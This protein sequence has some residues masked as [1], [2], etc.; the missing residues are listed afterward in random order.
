LGI[1]TG[2]LALTVILAVMNGFQL[3]FI[4][5]ILE[6]SSYHLRLESFPPGAEGEAL[7]EKLS[8]LPSVRAAAPFREI[9]GIA[10]GRTL[11]WQR[12]LRGA[13]ARGLPPD[14]LKQ[15][16]GLAEKLV[17]EAGSFNLEDKSSIALGAELA[18]RLD[19]IVGDW[20]T[21]V[22]VSADM[23]ELFVDADGE[24]ADH[25]QFRVEGI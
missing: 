2:V 25:S 8:A 23:G 17:F 24:G 12:G 6:I 13:V 22:S 10:R 14:A 16:P 21:L 1:A 7:R 20:I 9:Q 19:V 3:G 5:S 18:Q 15:D 4:E 11:G